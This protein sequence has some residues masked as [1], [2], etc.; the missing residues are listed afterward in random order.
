MMLSKNPDFVTKPNT[1]I[2][3]LTLSFANGQT[4]YVPLS[5]RGVASLVIPA[6]IGITLSSTTAQVSSSIKTE[7]SSFRQEEMEWIEKHRDEL[8]AFQGKWVAIE[9]N[10]LISSS[11][12]FDEAFARAKSLGID[13]PFIFYI[14]SLDEDPLM[15]L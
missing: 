7:K 13:V 15:G 4:P 1:K 11:H 2:E 12:N 6:T 5:D 10:K 9:G 14:P 3:P 8:F